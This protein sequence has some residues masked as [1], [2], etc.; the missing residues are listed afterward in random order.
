[1]I[2]KTI[3]LLVLYFFAVYLTSLW[4]K[5]YF[6]KLNQQ[7]G[8]GAGRSRVFLAP[9]SRSRLKKKPGAGARAGAGWGKKSGAEAGA[10]WK[11]MSGAGAGAE[12]KFAGSPALLEIAAKKVRITIYSFLIHVR[13]FFFKFLSPPSPFLCEK[14]NSTSNA[15]NRIM[16]L[17]KIFIF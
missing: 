5:E 2:K 15:S 14:K 6:G 16:F 7:S 4:R 17:V 12:K 13:L 9:W 1:M 8:A 3:I 10:G 11:K